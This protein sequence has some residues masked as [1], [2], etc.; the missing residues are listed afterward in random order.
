MSKGRLGH[1]SDVLTPAAAS[2][3]RSLF[4]DLEAAKG[5]D[6]GRAYDKATFALHLALG[7]HPNEA[8]CKTLAFRTAVRRYH[9]LTGTPQPEPPLA[10][11]IQL[12]DRR[13]AD[14]P[15]MSSKESAEYAGC[16]SG[17]GAVSSAWREKLRKL[18]ARGLA[19]KTGPHDNSPI[20]VRRSVVD[21]LIE[22]RIDLEEGVR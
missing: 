7:K 4:G 2:L 20:R 15:W 13:P 12:A 10:P 5:A 9:E 22:G 19:H 16:L 21:D 1:P 18:E 8:A 17:N 11:V 6:D 3:I 14:D